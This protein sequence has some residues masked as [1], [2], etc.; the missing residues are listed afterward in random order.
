M[1]YRRY[2]SPGFGIVGYII[3][4][5]VAVWIAVSIPARVNLISLLG[6]RPDD[7]LRMEQPWTVVTSMFV[8]APFPGFSHILFNMLILYFFGNFL[9]NLVGDK[10]FLL[11]YFLGGLAGNLA[12][13]FL[14]LNAF[15]SPIVIGASGAIFAVEGALVV[16]RPRLPVIIFPV[17]VPIPLWAS[18]VGAFVLTSLVASVAWEAHLGGL[19]LGLAAGYFFRKRELGRYWS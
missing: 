10:K 14:N 2:S 4:T 19:L 12:F 6:F 5:C 15:P 7:L 17:P 1:N 16:M 9:I 3:I 18:V 13:M 8:H 11:V